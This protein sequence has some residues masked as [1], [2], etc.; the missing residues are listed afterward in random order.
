MKKFLPILLLP[1]SVFLSGCF[2]H[3]V[4]GSHYYYP[5]GSK[6]ENADYHLWIEFHG[7]K[8]KAFT[9]RTKKKIIIGINNQKNN[10]FLRAYECV[11]ADINSDV[12]WDKIDNL[13]ITFFDFEEGISIYDRDDAY[14]SGKII[15]TLQLT[16]SPSLEGGK[17]IEKPISAELK[18]KIRNGN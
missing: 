16:Y 13:R 15:F 8:R 6:P 11:A 7:K 18:N 12:S 2:M 14:K 17:F 1:F 3:T 9:D 5:Q 4:V 10:V